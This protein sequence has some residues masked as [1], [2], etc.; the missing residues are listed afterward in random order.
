MDDGVVLSEPSVASIR[1][2]VLSCNVVNGA[3]K[4]R[5]LAFKVIA[6]VGRRDRIKW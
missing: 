2:T 1:E 4:W 6:G 3:I 5:V